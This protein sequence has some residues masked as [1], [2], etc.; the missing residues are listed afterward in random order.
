[1]QL[2]SIAS[3]SIDSDLDLSSIKR[4]QRRPNS[5][6]KRPLKLVRRALAVEFG[7]PSGCH[8]VLG[9]PITHNVLDIF[10]SG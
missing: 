4:L 2:P 10:V 9:H 6:N 1:M 5:L 3:S 8:V 7:A